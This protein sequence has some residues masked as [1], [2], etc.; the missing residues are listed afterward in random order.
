MPLSL[1]PARKHIHKRSIQLDGYERED[2]LWD[3]E[4]HLTDVKSYS[5]KN[6]FRGELKPNEYIHDMW[7]RLTLDDDL[8][9]CDIETRID[10]SPY[11]ICPRVSENYKELKGLKIGIGW[12]RSIKQKVG[13]KL[14]CTHLTELL[15]PLATVAIQTIMPLVASRKNQ[16][17]ITENSGKD[18]AKKP[19]L[20]NTCYNWSSD[21][22]Y[23]KENKP[24]FYTGQ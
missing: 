19:M 17:N 2:G 1:S 20:L 22:D 24:E 6:K 3:I 8:T 5:F 7:I 18:K 12:R 4:G 11:K 15:A 14:G 23:I 13:S 21:G 10:D 9:I 16:K